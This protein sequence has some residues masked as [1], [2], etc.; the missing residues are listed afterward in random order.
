MWISDRD[1][2]KNFFIGMKFPESDFAEY[3]K[4]RKNI[5]AEQNN[6]IL[7]SEEVFSEAEQLLLEKNAEASEQIKINSLWA[8]RAFKNKPT[9]AW[10][11]SDDLP[12]KEDFIITVTNNY[13]LIHKDCVTLLNQ[14]RIGKNRFIPLP[15]YEHSTKKLLSND[16][17]YFFELCDW[18]SFFIPEQS[19][20][21]CEPQPRLIYDK[22]GYLSH[23]IL[24][25][26][27]SKKLGGQVYAV[28]KEANDC[29]LDLWHDPQINKSICVSDA[30]KQALETAGM[31]H[32]WFFQSCKAL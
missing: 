16:E 29:D 3:T 13:I 20:P 21:A 25:F 22:G 23:E 24:S 14:F 17:W 10:Y 2:Y 18:R 27:H 19:N 12:K 5:I 8:C 28:S 26:E 11:W 31:A 4:K 7:P 1:D 15:M 30:L 32:A 6:Q 9:K